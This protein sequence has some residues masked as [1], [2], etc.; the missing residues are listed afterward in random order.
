MF[1]FLVEITGTEEMATAGFHVVGL[2]APRRA[3]R[4]R[5]QRHGEGEDEK[6]AEYWLH[7]ISLLRKDRSEPSECGS[8]P[9]ARRAVGQRKYTTTA[10]EQLAI[11]I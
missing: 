10:V 5:G 6:T 8:T 3:G 7:V 2:H 9:V 11:E 1:G 4:K